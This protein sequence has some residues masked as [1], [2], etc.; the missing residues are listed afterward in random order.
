MGAVFL[1]LQHQGRGVGQLAA[2][3]G[4]GGQARQ[5]G[6][7]G[8]IVLPAHAVAFA[9]EAGQDF[10]KAGGERAVSRRLGRRF[11]VAEADDEVARQALAATQRRQ[12][13]VIMVLP[14]SSPVEA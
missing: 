5:F 10:V 1:H 7:G 9:V 11:A 8:D 2:V 14:D 3:G 13:P 4:L 6:Q 12:A